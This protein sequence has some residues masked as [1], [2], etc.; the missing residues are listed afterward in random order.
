MQLKTLGQISDY[1]IYSDIKKYKVHVKY[2]L[3][4]GLLSCLTK[5]FQLL[6]TREYDHIKVLRP[7]HSLFYINADYFR[8][9]LNRLC[10]L[11]QKEE[12]LTMCGNVALIFI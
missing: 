12:Q 9:H 2:H 5:L 10:P 4:R 7:T 6:K 3:A 11:K 1:E 8:D